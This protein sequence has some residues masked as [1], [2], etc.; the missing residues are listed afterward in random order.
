MSHITEREGLCCR[1]ITLRDQM[2][3]EGINNVFK[4]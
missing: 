4:Y 2:L 1:L 3:I